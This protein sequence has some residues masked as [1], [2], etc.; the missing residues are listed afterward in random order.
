[1]FI[2]SYCSCFN[3]SLRTSFFS[4]VI[5]IQIQHENVNLFSSINFSLFVLWLNSFFLL[6][7]CFLFLFFGAQLIDLCHLVL[8]LF[9]Q[10]DSRMNSSQPMDVYYLDSAV[11]SKTQNPNDFFQQGFGGY[12]LFFC[13]HYKHDSSVLAIHF[14]FLFDSCV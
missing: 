9:A 8:S 11:H 12:H 5:L 1:M 13:T 3:C 7:I 2:F 14:V 4:N 6:S 10:M